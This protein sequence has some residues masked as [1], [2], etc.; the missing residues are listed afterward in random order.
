MSAGKRHPGF[1]NPWLYG[2]GY[3]PLTD[4]VHGGG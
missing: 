3:K 1:L 2:D 4:I